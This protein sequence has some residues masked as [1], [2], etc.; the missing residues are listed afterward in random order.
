MYTYLFLLMWLTSLF[1][2]FCMVLLPQNRITSFEAPREAAARGFLFFFFHCVSG[3]IAE[4]LLHSPLLS[5]PWCF[6]SCY[7]IWCN[8]ARR[9]GSKVCSHTFTRSGLSAFI[10]SFA[11]AF[12]YDVSRKKFFFLKSRSARFR[13]KNILKRQPVNTIFHAY[14]AYDTHRQVVHVRVNISAG[15]SFYEGALILGSATVSQYLRLCRNYWFNLLATPF[16]SLASL[17]LATAFS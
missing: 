12:F 13:E 8:Q 9:V 2:L 10:S 3:L 1:L 6:L 4:F 11:F 15:C 7:L 14:A 5:R 16:T 17:R